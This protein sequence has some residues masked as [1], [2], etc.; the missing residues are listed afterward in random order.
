MCLCIDNCLKVWR[1]RGRN[2]FW[3]GKDRNQAINNKHHLNAED[4]GLDE[5]IEPSLHINCKRRQPVVTYPRSP[6][7]NKGRNAA[8]QQDAETPH[9]RCSE[10]RNAGRQNV[11]P[12]IGACG[13]FNHLKKQVSVLIVPIWETHVEVNTCQTSPGIR[14]ASSEK[15]AAQG[16][17]NRAPQ[18]FDCV[19]LPACSAWV[20]VR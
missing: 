5:E 8:R 7:S 1:F 12:R 20:L 17:H 4:P 11:A 13:W 2:S 16:N 18:R 10:N 19:V 14:K 9:D 15:I 6:H 3:L